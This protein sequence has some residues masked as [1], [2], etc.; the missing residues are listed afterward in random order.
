[1]TKGQ[2]LGQGKMKII[3]SRNVIFG[4]DREI[5]PN[6]KYAITIYVIVREVITNYQDQNIK[7]VLTMTVG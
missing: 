4:Q 1:M 7:F 3:L 6:I 5:L 2:F